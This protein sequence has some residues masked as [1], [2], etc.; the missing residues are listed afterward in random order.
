VKRRLGRSFR[1]IL[2]K[3]ATKG[4][5]ENESL[6]FLSAKVTSTLTDVHCVITALLHCVFL[7]CNEDKPDLQSVFMR[8]G[9]REDLLQN[10]QQMLHQT[11]NTPQR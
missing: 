2:T 5:I 8:K 11:K 1:K 3:S 10:G 6:T 7:T 4:E 9:I